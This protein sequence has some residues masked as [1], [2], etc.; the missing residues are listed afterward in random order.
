MHRFQILHFPGPEMARLSKKLNSKFEFFKTK[1]IE[2]SSF[3]HLT[4]FFQHCLLCLVKQCW[5]KTCQMR[6]WWNF[7]FFVL[8]NSNFEFSFL[9]NPAISGPGKCKIRNL[10]IKMSKTPKYG[11]WEM[12]GSFYLCFQDISMKLTWSYWALC[13]A[14]FRATLGINILLWL[15]C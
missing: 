7:N 4:S 2:I 3:S 15:C 6:E 8:K 9:D 10:Y 12:M 1:K 11:L 5:K 14:V 13:P